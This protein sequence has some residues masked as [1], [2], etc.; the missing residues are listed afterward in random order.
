MYIGMGYTQ[1]NMGVSP[2]K[3]DKHVEML[4]STMTYDMTTHDDYWSPVSWSYS[5]NV[6]LQ[7]SP[8]MDFNLLPWALR[9]DRMQHIT[10]LNVSHCFSLF[11]LLVLHAFGIGIA[12][13]VFLCHGFHFSS[14]L[15][16][17][18]P[19]ALGASQLLAM[20]IFLSHSPIFPGL[21]FFWRLQ[22]GARCSTT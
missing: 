17:F 11:L 2:I 19:R 5:K 8:R 20:L 3:Q 15:W 1:P 4:K 9:L 13:E 21:D 22:K 7:S 18:L 16:Y 14:L 6:Q 10:M 12:A